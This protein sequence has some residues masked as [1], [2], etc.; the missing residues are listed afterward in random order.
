MSEY[1]EQ[2]ANSYHPL[3][4]PKPPRNLPPFLTV[5]SRRS[6]LMHCA[7]CTPEGMDP[8]ESIPKRVGQTRGSLQ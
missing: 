3:V 5:S 4:V 1:L 8:A 7:T 6:K 2:C